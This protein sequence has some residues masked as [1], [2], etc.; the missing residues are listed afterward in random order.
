[1]PTA[2][3]SAFTCSWF[4]EFSVT[5]HV[6]TGIPQADIELMDAPFAVR[7]LSSMRFKATS[8]RHTGFEGLGW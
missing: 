1:M 2:C 8:L 4:D 6:L 3:V 7:P 5:G